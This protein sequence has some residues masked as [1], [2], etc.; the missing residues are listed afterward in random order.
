MQMEAYKDGTNDHLN[1]N[2][3]EFYWK[4]FVTNEI[5]GGNALDFACG[6]GRNIQNLLDTQKFDN[7]DGV[8]ISKANI[9]SC[10]IRFKNKNVELF[11]NDGVSLKQLK[12][13]NY[14]Y[15]MST[16]ALQHIPVYDIRYNIIK[17]IF[18]CLN[19]GGVFRFQMGYGPYPKNKLFQIF[20]KAKLSK[21]SENIYS[22]KGTNSS[23]DVRI[24]NPNEILSDLKK[25]GFIE[26]TFHITE[27]F[28]D[29]Q[30]PEWIWIET[31]KP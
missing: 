16:I 17:D 24:S 15:V 1:H 28:D 25:I 2:Q 10:K 11:Q 4:F 21:F 8:D 5:K 9:E 23:Y 29:N 12:S 14:K 7:V 18:R 30:H 13:N 6:K 31:K 26:S 27:S 19:S 20:T 22:A 3:N